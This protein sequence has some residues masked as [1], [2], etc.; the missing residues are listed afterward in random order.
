MIIKWSII[1]ACWGLICPLSL[2]L[3]AAQT[4]QTNPDAA[5]SQTKIR[6]ARETTVLT[7]PLTEDGYVDYIAG[8]NA[9]LER[10]VTYENNGAVDFVAAMDPD[11]VWGYH[12]A[13]GIDNNKRPRPFE[14]WEA[15]VQ[16]TAPNAPLE[17]K[18]QLVSLR[19]TMAMGPWKSEQAPSVAEWLEA[20]KETIDVLAQSTQKPRFY[21]PWRSDGGSVIEVLLPAIQESRELT[22]TLNARA[23]LRLGEGDIDGAWSDLQ[24]CHALARQIGGGPTVVERLVG[25]AIES[26]ALSSDV[27]FIQNAA[28]SPEEIKRYQQTLVTM[29]RI[30]AIAEAIDHAERF[31]FLDA[32]QSIARDGASRLRMFGDTPAEP[33]SRALGRLLTWSVDWNETLIVGNQWYDQCVEIAQLN[34]VPQRRK[35]SEELERQ[36]LVA[37]E[38]NVAKLFFRSGREKGRR[39]GHVILS[40][41]LPALDAASNAESRVIDQRQLVTLAFAAEAYREKYDKYP[42]RLADLAPQF[43]DKI[44]QDL[45]LEEPYRY[46]TNG[47]DYRIFG[48]GFNFQLDN[49]VYGMDNV[50]STAAWKIER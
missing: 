50:V 27:I 47:Q 18:G 43:I 8:M 2:N 10:G 24:A 29:P 6:I 19:D 3:A 1:V 40:L 28:L 34:S 33:T 23:M 25:I 35:R 20:N 42:D 26:V 14:T 45:F 13:L 22:R 48:A 46:E 21:I 12:K 39:L 38:G 15:R 4:S 32:T 11:D 31:S 41:T 30:P 49:A 17:V 37:T 9:I 16:A 44:S 7:E 5:K 36:L